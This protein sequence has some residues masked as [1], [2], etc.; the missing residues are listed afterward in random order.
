MSIISLYSEVEYIILISFPSYPTKIQWQ[1]K[2]F[3]HCQ[4]WSVINSKVFVSFFFL[5]L[6]YLCLTFHKERFF[7]YSK[8]NIDLKSSKSIWEYFI[9]VVHYMIL[10]FSFQFSPKNKTYFK[11]VHS[12]GYGKDEVLKDWILISVLMQL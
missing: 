11:F 10:Y 2:D 3:V 9:R 12:Y 6:L 4:L 1:T 7:S 5:S 8:K